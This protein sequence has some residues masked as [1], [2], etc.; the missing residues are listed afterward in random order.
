MSVSGFSRTLQVFIDQTT[1]Q[2]LRA[3]HEAAYREKRS[4]QEQQAARSG[5]APD[6]TIV[7]DG[8]PG[9]PIEQ[10]KSVVVLQFF[11]WKEIVSEAYRLLQGRAPKRSGKYLE[12]FRVFVDG[13]P[14]EL[15]RIP[16]N[17]SELAIAPS[18]PYAR[19]LETGKKADGR[20]FVV[21]VPPK[22]VD[23]VTTMLSKRYGKVASFKTE[24]RGLSGENVPSPRRRKGGRVITE[25]TYPSIVIRPK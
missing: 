24:F 6:V 10:A 13:S 2:G 18:V 20:P 23:A 7:S 15:D 3:F 22:I 21:Q 5:I 8:V 16:K 4:V 1:Q 11:Y 12:S 25:M 19:R 17:F 9:R 14:T